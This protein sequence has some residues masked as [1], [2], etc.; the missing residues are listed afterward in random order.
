MIH[1]HDSN[2]NVFIL[3]IQIL[4]YTYLN[5]EFQ[6]P[7]YGGCSASILL[8]I[9]YLGLQA[10]E[11]VKIKRTSSKVTNQIPPVDLASSV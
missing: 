5:Y 9:A 10:V 11:E 7:N 1:W 3:R 4:R 2:L 8:C 6:H